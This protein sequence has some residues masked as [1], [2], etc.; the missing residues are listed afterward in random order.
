[1]H[2]HEWKLMRAT[3]CKLTYRKKWKKNQSKS[4]PN[5][6]N[7]RNLESIYKWTQKVLQLV[8]YRRNAFTKRITHFSLSF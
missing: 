7:T 2:L 6:I 8:L 1:M 3:T 4:K 5:L